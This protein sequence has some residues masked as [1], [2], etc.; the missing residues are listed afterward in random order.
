MANQRLQLGQLREIPVHYDGHLPHAMLLHGAHET[1]AV[2]PP[3]CTVHCLVPAWQAVQAHYTV[4]VQ[5]KVNALADDTLTALLPYPPSHPDHQHSE[6]RRVLAFLPDEVT[7]WTV[8]LLPAEAHGGL[9]S[10]DVAGLNLSC[11]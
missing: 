7:E 10:T 3:Y 9:I 5:S 1:A 2:H 6:K 11:P 4:P 8:A